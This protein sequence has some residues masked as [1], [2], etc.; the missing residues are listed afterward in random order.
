MAS[1]TKAANISFAS[2]AS[3]PARKRTPSTNRRPSRAAAF[4]IVKKSLN[5]I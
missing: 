1:S 4:F 2:R 5:N 3:I